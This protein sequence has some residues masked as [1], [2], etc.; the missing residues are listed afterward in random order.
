MI[1]L[2]QKLKEENLRLTTARQVIFDILK[3]S[4]TALSAQEVCKIMK[5]SKKLKA[6]QASVYRNLITFTQ[7]GIVHQISHGKY[8]LCQ[9]GEKHDH[10]H[11]HIVANCTNCDKTYEIESHDEKLCK[12]AGGFRMYIKD[13]KSFSGLTLQGQCKDCS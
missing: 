1:R 11:L 8:S 2:E 6:D 7:I 13:F 9:H 4:S 12:M 10:G 5:G 3:N